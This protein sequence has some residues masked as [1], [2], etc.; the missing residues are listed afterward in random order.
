MEEREEAECSEGMTRFDKLKIAAA[1]IIGVT[2]EP[3]GEDVVGPVV[4]WEVVGP[5]KGSDGANDEVNGDGWQQ[6]P[7]E[8][9]DRA[10][11]R[12]CPTCGFGR[13]V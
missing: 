3:G 13:A 10:H 12:R 4:G 9:A 8:A 11:R 1:R 6:E 7:R 2:D 5:G